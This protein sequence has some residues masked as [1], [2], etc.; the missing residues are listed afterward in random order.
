MKNAIY[1]FLSALT[2]VVILSPIFY[3]SS[4]G[5]ETYHE[6]DKYVSPSSA[7]KSKINAPFMNSMPAKNAD[8][9]A[10]IGSMIEHKDAAWFLKIKGSYTDAYLEQKNLKKIHQELLT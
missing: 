2:V 7:I 1:F 9:G 8:D 4:N 6:D 5:I 10:I 3:K